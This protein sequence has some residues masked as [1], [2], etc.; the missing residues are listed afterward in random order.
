MPDGEQPTKRMHATP[1]IRKRLFKMRDVKIGDCFGESCVFK[2]QQLNWFTVSLSTITCYCIHKDKFKTRLSAVV[3]SS[4]QDETAFR[5]AYCIERF[6]RQTEYLR[7][8]NNT[9]TGECPPEKTTDEW[10]QSYNIPTRDRRGSDAFEMMVSKRPETEEEQLK[11]LLV[12]LNSDPEPV[13]TETNPVRKRN[14]STEQKAPIRNKTRRSMVN[15]NQAP[16]ARSHN[17]RMQ[18]GSL[19]LEPFTVVNGKGKT[20]T[21]FVSSFEEPDKKG[22]RDSRINMMGREFH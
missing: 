18:R 12:A 13:R 22:S 14:D 19:I 15:L 21:E 9:P 8:K 11:E 17:T 7:N 1:K 20:T 5:N 16:N 2:S 3:K 6:G 10:T 4:I